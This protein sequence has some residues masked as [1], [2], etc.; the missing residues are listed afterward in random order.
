MAR[1]RCHNRKIKT[2]NSLY[3]H[4]PPPGHSQSHCR[5]HFTLKCRRVLPGNW[6]AAQMGIQTMSVSVWGVGVG[7]GY[8][9]L[10]AG[11]TDIE[12]AASGACEAAA[13]NGIKDIWKRKPGH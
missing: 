12:R 2:N 13:L 5:R 10:V 1:R 9:V 8:F 11:A 7:W 4:T 6:A 3:A